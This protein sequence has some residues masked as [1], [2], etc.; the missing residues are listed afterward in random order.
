MCCHPVYP[1]WEVEPTDD[2]LG[3]ILSIRGGSWLKFPS[4]MLL[5]RVILEMWYLQFVFFNYC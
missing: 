3:S 1:K 5:R 2:Q 4:N